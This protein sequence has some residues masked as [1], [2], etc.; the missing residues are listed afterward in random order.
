MAD[1]FPS[2]FEIE[3]PP[4]AEG[5]QQMY[6]YYHVLAEDRRDIDDRRFWFQDQLHHGDVLYPYDEI[7]CECWWPAL[8]A[9]NTRI[10][11]MPP[12]FGV[13]QRVINGYLYISP[14]PVDDPA[15]IPQRAELYKRRAGYYYDNWNELYERWKVKTVVGLDRIKAIEFAPLP[16]LEDEEVVFSARGYSTSYQMVH[17]FGVLVDTM[18]ETYQYHFEFLNIGYA[19]YLTYFAFC[20]QAF[21]DISDQSIARMVGGLAVDLYR[22]DDELKR[23]AKSAVELGVADKIVAAGDAE[24]VWS[25]LSLDGDAGKQWIADYEQTSDPWFLVSLDPG[26]PGGYHNY[27]TWQD[28]PT[29]PVSSIQGY[30]RRLQAGESIDRPTAEVLAER[31]RIAS[32]Y[33]S[34]LDE[35][36]QKGFDEILALARLVFVYIEEHVLYIEHWLWAT[37]WK[38]SRE[39]AAALHAMDVFDRED[40]MFFLNRHEVA[41]LLYDVHAGWSVGSR[42]RGKSYWGPIVEERRRIYE[43]LKQWSPPPA[44]GVP[45][46]EVTEPFTVM[47]WGITTERV[48]A[49][50]AADEDGGGDGNTLT[51]AAA[52][53]G[54]VEGLARVVRAVSEL[55]D[56]QQGEILVCPATSPAW[57]PIF[58]TIAAVV[59]DVGGMMSHTA[60]VC[61][62]Y[63]LPAVVGTGYACATIQTGQR[64]RVDGGSGTVTILD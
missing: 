64:L 5:W 54:T 13:D 10:F 59:S 36:Q 28:D 32:E 14:I 43:T 22:P 46:E 6:S 40:D 51:G 19:A 26:H 57:A 8:G 12:A 34:V 50:L 21:P 29:V 1:R 63:G 31:D 41:Q 2:P 27:G 48:K 25:A 37:F 56:V 33:R 18:Y 23:L 20:K 24:A 39:L 9:F 47:L 44:L 61:R 16:A 7:Q 15:T 58:P 35:E 45:P 17:D 4:G 38:K 11:A 42:W 60:I 30:I 3:T 55:G 49:W 52:S 62:E 53:P